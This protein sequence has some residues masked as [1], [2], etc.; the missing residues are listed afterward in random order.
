[1][2][3]PDIDHV[4]WPLEPAVSP[5]AL[6]ELAIC[7]AFRRSEPVEWDPLS[8]TVQCELDNLENLIRNWLQHREVDSYQRAIEKRPSRMAESKE[9]EI[10]ELLL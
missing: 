10:D 4:Y 3:K 2:A 6:S 8:E 9:D 1:M 7:I 5:L